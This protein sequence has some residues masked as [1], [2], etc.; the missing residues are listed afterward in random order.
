MIGQLVSFLSFATVASA[1]T[2]TGATAQIDAPISVTLSQGTLGS[3]PSPA[4]PQRESI[5]N[6]KP[7]KS[8]PDS[9]SDSESLKSATSSLKEVASYYERESERLAHENAQLK[10]L[11]DDGLIARNEVEAN[12]RALAEAQAKVADIQR[13]IE[14]EATRP[15]TVTNI[16]TSART[17]TTGQTRIDA[18][19]R[20]Q[21]AQY[22][23][24]PY[25][26]YCVMSQ[27]SS[28]AATSVSPKGA[29]GLMQLMPATAARYGVSNPL[30][31]VQSIRA[32]TH[33]LKDLLELFN[34]RIDLALAGYN[35]GE[36]A[37]IKYGNRIPP[38]AETQS[39]VRLI[40]KRYLNQ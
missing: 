7:P 20:D 11:Y 35:A 2:T 30:D 17:W 21:G 36:G 4:A 27:E 5:D 8:T 37:V 18:L 28:F 15:T 6:Q 22:G 26:I 33:Y 13:L 29:K 39:Y 34:G 25:L 38:Y 12:D 3:Q 40:S 24:D 31:P 9:S 16:V 1:Q 10:E 32:G 19:I 14:A 23:I